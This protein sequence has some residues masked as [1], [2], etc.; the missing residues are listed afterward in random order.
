[1][2][3]IRDKVVFSFSI[4]GTI[5]GIVYLVMGAWSKSSGAFFIGF[6]LL[7]ISILILLFIGLDYKPN[8]SETSH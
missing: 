8:S 2:V 7:L 3:R 5:V 1:M 6:P 4:V